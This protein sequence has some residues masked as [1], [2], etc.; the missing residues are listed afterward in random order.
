MTFIFFLPFKKR[1]EMFSKLMYTFKKL[2]RFFKDARFHYNR[3]LKCSPKFAALKVD[4]VF[5]NTKALG[6]HSVG[7]VSGICLKQK[8]TM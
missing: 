2:L 7:I 3:C 1:K 4:A 8:S 6:Q 5:I